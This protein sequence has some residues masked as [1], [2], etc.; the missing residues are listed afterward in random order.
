MGW[1]M[2]DGEPQTEG[3]RTFSWFTDVCKALI[4]KAKTKG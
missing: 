3:K 1:V 4:T 2:S